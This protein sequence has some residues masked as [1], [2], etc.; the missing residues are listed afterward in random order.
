MI[1]FERFELPNG[2][3]V[4]V[5]EDKSTPLA[6]FNLM[7]DVG[8]RDESPE[9]TGFAHLFEHL[10]F[11][12][13]VN[14]PDFDRELQT[15][16]GENN[17]FTSNDITNYYCTVPSENLE[18]AFWLD[19]DRMLELD[20]SEHSLD[21]QRQVV[22]EEFRQRYLNQPYGDVWLIL[23][24][25]AF[26]I[27]PYRW[28]TIGRS[29]EHIQCAGIED[30]KSFFYRFYAPNNAVL[31]ITGNV[32]TKHVLALAEK[33][34]GPIGRRDISKR[35]LPQEP[36]QTEERNIDITRKV[37]T[38][39]IYKV[40]HM[41]GLYTRGFYH[42]DIL[43][44]ILASG[45]SARLFQNLI[46]EKQLFSEINAY[47]TGDADPGLFVVYGKPMPGV[48]LDDADKAIRVELNRLSG[49]LLPD[50]ELQKL[51]NKFESTFILNHTNILNKAIH[52]CRHELVDNADNLNHEIE[53]YHSI[54]ADEIRNA[55]GLIF[56]PTNCTTL[57]YHKENT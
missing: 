27:H 38:D 1:G 56:K 16:G 15:V 35:E 32:D 31:S 5:H 7:Y 53:T 40:F 50:Q 12:G 55:A 2:L 20:F 45:K 21:V 39:A 49:Q 34:F 13:S 42:G 57:Y 29:I 41:D 48:S 46:K 51:K 22:I 43:S 24:P 10:M 17:A 28:P 52:L 9:K 36:P 44:D 23:R 11:G 54:T 3:R 18:T 30:V 19:S 33:W 8:S 26:H 47:I 37:P 6:A 25:E 14:V 4:L